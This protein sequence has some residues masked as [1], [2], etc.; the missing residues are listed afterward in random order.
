[1]FCKSFV[2]LPFSKQKFIIQG[3]TANLQNI[4]VHHNDNTVFT[5]SKSVGETIP[6]QFTRSLNLISPEKMFALKSVTACRL[7]LDSEKSSWLRNSASVNATTSLRVFTG[8]LDVD[9]AQGIASEM[10]RRMKKNPPKQATF[11]LIFVGKDEFDAREKDDITFKDF[12][13]YPNQGQVFIGFRTH[14]TTGCTVHIASRFIP[15]VERESIDFADP[16]IGQW[17]R[18]LLSI[19]GLLC[20]IV[21]DD[22]LNQIHRLFEESIINV[23]VA[24][25]KI[26]LGDK[27]DKLLKLEHRAIHTLR[28]LSFHKST[29]SDIVGKTHE[30]SFFRMARLPIMV[31]TTHGVVPVSEARLPDED[32]CQFI[33]TIPIIPRETFYRCKDILQKLMKDG[34]L[35]NITINDVFGELGKRVLTIAETISLIKWWIKCNATNPIEAKISQETLLNT[36]KFNAGNQGVIRL[37]HIRFWRNPSV[38]A[39]DEPIPTTVL[40]F[41]I[42]KEFKPRIDFAKIFPYGLFISEFGDLIVTKS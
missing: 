16:Y 11:S 39:M 22:E 9:V 38:V 32:L 10:N 26:T 21:Y 42:S 40:P 2:V 13:T 8:H 41:E 12:V 24:D 19:G 29:P 1:M 27:D 31:M 23:D 3:F 7:R 15:T 33:R 28:G 37:S 6:I 34:R 36:V 20:R 14:Q 18:E 4:A 5:L 25:K 30:D 17:N 35:K